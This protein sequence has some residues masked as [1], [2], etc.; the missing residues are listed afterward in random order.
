MLGESSSQREPGKTSDSSVKSGLTCYP[1]PTL[2]R[3][4]H[5][6]LVNDVKGTMYSGKAVRS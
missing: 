5:L 1:D 4:S 3:V 6:S 2:K